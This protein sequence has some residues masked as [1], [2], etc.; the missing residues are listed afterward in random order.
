[1]V[2]ENNVYTTFH[3]W[4]RRMMT[5]DGVRRCDASSLSSAFSLD[6]DRFK[7]ALRL[8][9]EW[10]CIRDHTVLSM[11]SDDKVLYFEPRETGV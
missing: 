6:V 4:F 3:D 9:N 2:G 1:M 11:L 7:L 5:H 10:N 8:F